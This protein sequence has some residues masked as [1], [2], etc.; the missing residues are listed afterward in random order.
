M[1]KKKQLMKCRNPNCVKVFTTSSE[2]KH[3]CSDYCQKG[4]YKL[5]LEAGYKKLMDD[6]DERVRQCG[7]MESYCQMLTGRISGSKPYKKVERITINDVEVDV[8]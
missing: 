4:M 6:F 1:T 8:K 7:G 3:Y 2:N 5:A